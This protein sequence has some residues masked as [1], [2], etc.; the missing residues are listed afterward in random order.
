MILVLKN[1]LNEGKESIYDILKFE[2]FQSFQIGNAW[3]YSE[4]SNSF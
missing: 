1:V 4:K 2:K 3:K